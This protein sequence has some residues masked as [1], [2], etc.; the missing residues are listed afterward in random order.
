M[1]F[2]LRT[3]FKEVQ[4]LDV[5]IIYSV[6]KKTDVIPANKIW[7]SVGMNDVNY[8]VERSKDFQSDTCKYIMHVS[9]Y[10]YFSKIFFP[11]SSH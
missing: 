9:M 8:N 11:S 2:V 1:S 6:I 3:R 5:F 10:M 4:V 7:I